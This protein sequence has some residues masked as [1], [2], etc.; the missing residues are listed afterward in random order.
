MG[1]YMFCVSFYAA[2][3]SDMQTTTIQQWLYVAQHQLDHYKSGNV[4]AMLLEGISNAAAELL[5]RYR[6]GK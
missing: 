1:D 2:D 4:R 5:F 3:F 6:E